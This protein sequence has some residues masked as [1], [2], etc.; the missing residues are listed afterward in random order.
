MGVFNLYKKSLINRT[1]KSINSYDKDKFGHKVSNEDLIRRKQNMFFLYYLNKIS[2]AD[3]VKDQSEQ[4]F[5]MS[6]LEITTKED[7]TKFSSEEIENFITETTNEERLSLLSSLP[8]NI[9][10]DFLSAMFNM[11]ISDDDFDKNE[12]DIIIELVLDLYPG[13]TE[14][15]VKKKVMSISASCKK[16]HEKTIG[17]TSELK[18]T[19][20][21]KGAITQV[22]AALS[23]VD[24]H[25]DKRESDVII[26]ILNEIEWSIDLQKSYNVDNF[27]SDIFSMDEDKKKYLSRAIVLIVFA[28][29][30]LV[31]EEQAMIDTLIPALKLD[32]EFI[33]GLIQEIQ[34]SA[35]NINPEDDKNNN[36]ELIDDNQ[37]SLKIE[38]SKKVMQDKIDAF[39]DDEDLNYWYEIVQAD[40]NSSVVEF[41]KKNKPNW[42][43]DQTVMEWLWGHDEEYENKM[44]GDSKENKTEF[45][46]MRIIAFGA[47]LEF[48]E[49][50]YNTIKSFKG[51]DN[52]DISDEIYPIEEQIGFCKARLY[53]AIKFALRHKISKKE[54][55]K[56]YKGF[57]ENE[58]LY[59]GLDPMTLYSEEQN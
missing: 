37:I 23:G 40:A 32:K 52:L 18:F 44:G 10:N 29:G 57:D 30:V 3:G 9:K 47:I 12:S 20:A 21:E 38:A 14:S 28:D 48:L 34:G 59:H 46:K 51:Y 58:D 36:E 13:I 43:L 27:V 4:N 45:I 5:Y 17:E 31:K 39:K 24:D 56:W 54:I 1:S 16:T 11:A 41:S 53:G 6:Q 35:E 25:V 22:I 7:G 55:K 15:E 49:E 19:K 26:E 2:L 33:D 50:H 42:T 8:E